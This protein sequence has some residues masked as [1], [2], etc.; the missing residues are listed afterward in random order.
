M[1]F[2]N[3]LLRTFVAVAEAENFTRAGQVVNRTQSAV[4]MQVKR[5]EAEVGHSLFERNGGSGGVSLTGKGVELLRYARRILALHDEAVAAV[6]RPGLEGKVRLGLPEDFSSTF[7]PGVLARFNES[8]PNVR[9]EV[10]CAPGKDISDMLE[11]GKLD[12][13]I[14]SGEA[15]EGRCEVLRQE[16]LAWVVSPSSLAHERD[17]VPL[18]VYWEGCSYRRWAIHALETMGRDYRIAFTSLSISGIFA[19]VRAGLAV[20]AVGVS[21]L[22]SDLM[23][24]GPADGYPVL[25]HASVT[26]HRAPGV[27][28]QLV[29]SLAEHVRE[30]FR[31]MK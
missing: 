31:E 4:S 11:N 8:H 6:A 2:P 1:Q 29:D 28:S 18:A 9:V 23:T 3:D 24:L 20:A 16:A 13:G 19:A 7:L 15:S 12:L 27:Q 10:M 5:L 21:N 14:H 30:A 25:P 26:L 22:T 17:P